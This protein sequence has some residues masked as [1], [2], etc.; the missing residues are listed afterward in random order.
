MIPARVEAAR[1]TRSAAAGTLNRR[2]IRS[3]A[4]MA[5]SVKMSS[6]LSLG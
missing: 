5:E 6:A 3:C 1:S 2:E 4:G